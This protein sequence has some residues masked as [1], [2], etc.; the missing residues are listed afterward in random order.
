MLDIMYEIPK[1]DSI[2]EVVITKRIH[3][4]KRWSEDPSSR[5]G[6][7]PAGGVSLIKI[8]LFLHYEGQ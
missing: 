7:D 5:T 4:R 8:V 1:D 3:R 2:G 6:A